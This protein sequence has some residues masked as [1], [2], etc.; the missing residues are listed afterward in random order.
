MGIA[1][2]LNQLCYNLTGAYSEQITA[3]GVLNDLISKLSGTE[4]GAER[5][6][7]ALGTL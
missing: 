5:L 4:T 6:G 1:K 3:R 7:Q 2:E